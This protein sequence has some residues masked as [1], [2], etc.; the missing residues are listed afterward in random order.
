MSEYTWL[1]VVWGLP[2]LLMLTES[3]RAYRSRTSPVLLW[4]ARGMCGIHDVAGFNRGVGRCCLVFS[5][6]F[7]VSGIPA[8]FSSNPFM[9]LLCALGVV[10]SFL[11]LYYD[12]T[13]LLRKYGKYAGK[14][15]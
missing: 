5:C 11:F 7:A 14:K 8:F 15:K 10:L 6:I 2:V 3:W 9:A 12:Y 4:K 1:L 13:G